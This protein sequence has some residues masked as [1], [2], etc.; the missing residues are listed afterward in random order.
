MSNKHRPNIE[1]LEPTEVAS[2]HHQTLEVT[3]NPTATVMRAARENA[4]HLNWRDRLRMTTSVSGM[5]TAAWESVYKVRI[6]LGASTEIHRNQQ[7][8]DLVQR[9][10][11]AAH[12]IATQIGSEVAMA[13]HVGHNLRVVD[14]HLQSEEYLRTL[15]QA[16]SR[17]IALEV[18]AG[19]LT[20][21]EAVAVIT[22]WRAERDAIIRENDDIRAEERAISREQLSKLLADSLPPLGNHR[23]NSI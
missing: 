11:R 1:I 12:R 17:S 3:E 13:A 4:K 15:I 20:E 22:K 23:A 14:L 18:E 2:N 21:A 10:D 6:Q 9:G 19:V 5:V 8:Y 7:T 16:G